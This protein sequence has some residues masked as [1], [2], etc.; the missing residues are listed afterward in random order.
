MDKQIAR[1]KAGTF[2]AWFDQV[3]DR[4]EIQWYDHHSPRAFSFPDEQRAR[5]FW[6]ENVIDRRG[7]QYCYCC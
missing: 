1:V 3:G 2:Q 5:E 7:F 6:H 4:Y